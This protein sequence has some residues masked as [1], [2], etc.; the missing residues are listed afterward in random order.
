MRLTTFKYFYPECPRLLSIEQSL[1]RRLSEHNSFVAEKKYNEQRLE[2]HCNGSFEFWNR[3]GE[4]LNYAPNKELSEA[5]SCLPLH[6]YCLFDGGL[7][8]NKV[9]GIQHK[10]MI[11]DVFVWQSQLLIGKPFWYRRTIIENLFKV[12][13]DPLGIP[14]QFTNKFD[15]VF[16]DVIKDP[17][18][19][20]LVIKNRG[21]ILKL[22][23]NAA[24]DSNWMWKVR[25][26]SGRYRF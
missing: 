10:I 13:G 25:K 8:H 11:Y 22:G 12:N 14:E 3:H 21:G 20:G 15:Q 6:G 9:P 19:E 16:T 24:Y 18:I 23:R 17:E 2:L 7:R 5:L 1:F 4:K 26:P